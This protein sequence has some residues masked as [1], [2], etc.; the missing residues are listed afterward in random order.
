MNERKPSAA[1]MRLAQDI[2]TLQQCHVALGRQWVGACTELPP[3]AHV[4]DDRGLA[5][6]I[7][8]IKRLMTIAQRPSV[9]SPGERYI[10]SILDAALATLVKLEGDQ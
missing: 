5:D 4:I 8:V 6:A 1:A 2:Q 3:I 9:G 10:N 7:E